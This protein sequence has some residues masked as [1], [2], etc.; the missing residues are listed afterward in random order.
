MELT[1]RRGCATLCA[2]VVALATAVASPGIA[3]GGSVSAAELSTEPSADSVVLVAAGDIAGCSTMGDEATADLIAGIPGTVAALGDIVYDGGD[4]E[5]FQKCYDPSWGRFKDRTRPVVGN[6]EYVVSGAAGYFDY[7]G[8]AAGER[9]KGYYSFDTGGWHVVVLNTNCAKVSC[10]VGSPQEQWLR[11]DLAASPAA[12]TAALAHHPRYSSGEHGDTLSTQPLWRALWDD[13]VELMLAGHDHHYERFQPLSADGVPATG[14]GIRE[15]VVGTG[16]RSHGLTQIA[17]DF[18]E[19]IEDDTYGALKLTLHDSGY[20]WDFAPVAGESFTD[21]GSA[22]CH[23]A[24]TDRARP[25]TS[26]SAGPAAVTGSTSAD[27]MF[28]SDE[29]LV[30]YS[31]VLDGGLAFQCPASY[32]LVGLAPGTHTLDVTARDAAGNVDQTSSSWSWEVM[33]GES[34]TTVEVG[35][36]ADAKVAPA[37]RRINYGSQHT[38]TVDAAPHSQD[39]V[40][41]N[42]PPV[43]GRI[44]SARLKVFAL[45]SSRNGPV[46]AR[47]GHGWAETAVTWADRPDVGPVVANA[48][49]VRA[50]T[51]V[52]YNLDSAVTSPGPYGFVLLPEAEDGLDLSAREAENGRGPRLVVRYLPSEDRIPTGTRITA[53]PAATTRQSVASFTFGS[54]EPD[55]E[56]T[57]TLDGGV[58]RGCSAPYAVGEVSPGR[59]ELV[60]RTHDADPAPATWTWEVTGSGPSVLTSWAFA[61]TADAHV[62]PDFATR[63]FGAIRDLGVDG[64]PRYHSLFRFDLSDLAGDVTEAGF[65][66]Q[67]TAGSVDGSQLW[68]TGSAW[69]EGQVTWENRPDL[70]AQVGQQASVVAEEWMHVPVTPVATAPGPYAFAVVPQGEDGFKLAS[71]EVIEERRPRLVVTA[72]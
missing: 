30:T 57:C 2:L 38:L 68:T 45:D 18:S 22:G 65:R 34:P 56:F 29:S 14:T 31:C 7:F 16:G 1:A 58:A 54:D 11:Q 32:S 4:L 55:A 23:G 47:T 13:G 60:V 61:A 35:A 44:I 59:H 8:A 3:G 15:F 36:A 46:L 42:V 26:I 52:D 66:A 51:W 9:G 21:A 64:A 69:T 53:G 62:S 10:A 19:V 24:P 33:T 25:S 70:R 6:H 40:R 63:N 49:K 43:E 48:G 41:F 37:G 5:H 39:Y 50:G 20:D 17:D 71:D 28:T 27:F 67:T 72:R 12:C